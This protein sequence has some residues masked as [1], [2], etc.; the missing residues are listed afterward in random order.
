MHATQE[1]Q[2]SRLPEPRHKRRGK[3]STVAFT[4]R[5]SVLS[6][7]LGTTKSLSKT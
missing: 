1:E 6:P 2:L 5:T 3:G 4:A 7:S